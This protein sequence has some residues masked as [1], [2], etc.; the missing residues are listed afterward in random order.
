MGPLAAS[1]GYWLTVDADQI[2]ALPATLTGSIGVIMG[3]FE[4][5]GMWD[6]VG[7][8]W[9]TVTWG[10]NAR[11][12]SMNTPLDAKGR[13]V[14]ERAID[15][16]YNDFLERVANGRGMKRQD[17]RAVAKGRAWTGTSAK[18]NGL[19]DEIGGLDDVLEKVAQDLGVPG[20][21]KLKVVVL[22]K[23]LSA[24]EE[25]MYLVGQQ[26]T[27]GKLDLGALSFLKPFLR[28][29][30]TI[31]RTGPVMAYDPALPSIIP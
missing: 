30:E 11:L 4:I 22:P 3:K 5:S 21:T 8:N 25:L 27:L 19:V 24:F 20:R 2:Y 29:A 23:P 6:K 15:S 7:V 9:D 10:E 31:Q 12:W 26:V 28:E 14:L 16:T 1:G 17:V 18:K 13:A